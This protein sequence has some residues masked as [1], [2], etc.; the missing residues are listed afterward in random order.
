MI[1]HDPTEGEDSFSS[2]L[3]V[4]L[5]PMLDVL[6]MLLVFLVLTANSAQLAL[7]FDL[8]RV[9][10]DTGERA[11]GGEDLVVIIPTGDTPWTVGE[12]SHPDWATARE[13][14]RAA[15][16]TAPEA[17]VTV[18]AA[19]DAPLE[20]AVDVLTFLRGEGLPSAAIL[21]ERETAP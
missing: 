6:F 11:P 4:D 1:T 14:I 10:E 5:T 3:E 18:A 20:R 19:R 17:G 7:D 8:P 15:L 21:I 2:G 9:S 12:D 13:A 16:T